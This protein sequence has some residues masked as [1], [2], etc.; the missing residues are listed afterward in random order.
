VQEEFAELTAFLD[1]NGVKYSAFEHAPVRTSEEAAAVR[2]VEMKTCVKALVFKIN[3]G[4]NKDVSVSDGRHKYGTNMP[5][6]VSAVDDLV[7][8]LVRG[9]HRVDTGK[10]RVVTG[11]KDVKLASP[12]EVLERTN[13]EIGSV[14]P[15]GNLFHLP[16]YMDCSILDAGNVNFSA[17]MHTRSIAMNA[18]DMVKL[19]S[20]EVADIGKE[21]V[22]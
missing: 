17:G 9:D 19:I 12:S 1:K 20:P 16:V 8:V 21:A 10:L 22:R 3:K 2:K 7:M 6:S 11:A 15:F 14:H 4:Q 13:C 18:S 5:P